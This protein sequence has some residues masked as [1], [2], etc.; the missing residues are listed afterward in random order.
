MEVQLYW[1][2]DYSAVFRCA[3]NYAWHIYFFPVNELLKMVLNEMEVI[4][5]HI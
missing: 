1:L 4:S 5:V 3:Q 2:K